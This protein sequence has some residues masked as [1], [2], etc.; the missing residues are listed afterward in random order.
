MSAEV[1]NLVDRLKRRDLGRFVT[2]LE[3][4]L[5]FLLDLPGSSLEA[6]LDGSHATDYASP[7]RLF[8]GFG[9]FARKKSLKELRSVDDSS[10]F[11]VPLTMQVIERI[12]PLIYFL[13]IEESIN[14]EGLFRK[15]GHLGRQ[16]MLRDKIN[17]G[18]AG[19]IS[20]D[21]KAGL[22]TVHD[23]ANV[24]K[25]FLGEL[26][27][28]VLSGRHY[29]AHCQVAE[30][31]N[32]D[33]KIQ[34][35]QLLIRLL[36]DE[37]FRL[38]KSLLFLLHSAARSAGNLMTAESLGTIF[39]PHLLVPKRVAPS[40]LHK[41]NQTLT[42]VVS[43]MIEKAPLLFSLPEA[44]AQD[45]RMSLQDLGTRRAC[46]STS[47]LD[48]KWQASSSNPSADATEDCTE[49]NTAVSFADRVASRQAAAE[50]DT[51]R[52]LGELYAHIAN[53]PESS[54]KRKLLKQ[55][56]QASTFGTSTPVENAAKPRRSRSLAQSLKK[57][58][59]HGKKG[60]EAMSIQSTSANES[61]LPISGGAVEKQSHTPVI[62][63]NRANAS[64]GKMTE[65]LLPL[66]RHLKFD[67]KQP[68]SLLPSTI[69]TNNHSQKSDFNMFLPFHPYTSSAKGYSLTNITSRPS[70]RQKHTSCPRIHQPFDNCSTK[71]DPQD[72][73][74]ISR[75]TTKISRDQAE[76]KKDSG[77]I[78]PVRRSHIADSLLP[79]K[80][81]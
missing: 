70:H 39:A 30:M 42:R 5:S 16:R 66:A 8:R 75:D 2:L 45:I 71:T 25:Q 36:P 72:T 17:F 58:V 4:H 14:K 21:L 20:A 3:M 69:K 9:N 65:Q 6:F 57:F 55:F 79:A 59:G 44:V 24:L 33:K 1:D 77:F 51:V 27:D 49:V 26:K 40:D 60:S 80:N 78:S 74:K 43:F 41:K 76:D 37:N 23:C 48:K 31:K 68:L 13:G 34:T 64:A 46:A 15:S 19:C 11:G 56:N 29:L 35:L 62:M 18:G 12:Q 22:F 32:E 81:I 7:E 73:P 50:T 52:A 47:D 54:K 38:L 67:H 63:Q 61:L 53:L 28:P 10:V